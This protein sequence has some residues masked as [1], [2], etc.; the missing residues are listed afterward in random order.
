[1]RLTV[2]LIREFVL[3][4]LN[5]FKSFIFTADG[6]IVSW[7]WIH[8]SVSQDSSSR[9]VSNGHKRLPFASSVSLRNNSTLL[10]EG[11]CIFSRGVHIALDHSS[12]HIGKN[13]KIGAFTEIHGDV[14]IGAETL[15]AP[16]C[17]FSSGTHSY[18]HSASLGISLREADDCFPTPSRRVR[19]GSNC[20]ICRNVVVLPGRVIGDNSVVGAN[21]VVNQDLA[22]SRVYRNI[23]CIVESAL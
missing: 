16:N 20:W 4:T 19:L 17:Y 21:L 6:Y 23:P 18:K 22:G 10:L 1:M 2:D 3:A 15:I 5:P 12:I 14:S 8:S 9:I 7:W 13:V 11:G